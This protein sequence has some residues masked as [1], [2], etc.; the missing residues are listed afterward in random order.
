MNAFGRPGRIP[1]SIDVPQK[2]LL[3]PETGLFRTPEE[4]SRYFI[5]V[6]TRKSE[7]FTYYGGGIFATVDASWLYQLGYDNV[8]V[9]DNSMSE[10]GA[11]ASL[12]MECDFDP[13]E[14]YNG[15]RL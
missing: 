11:D 5:E 2:E 9:Y 6:Q 3:D 12:P 1:R 7:G 13:R 14:S 15:A 10:W 8:A 4:I